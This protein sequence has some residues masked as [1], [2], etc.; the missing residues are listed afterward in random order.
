MRLI[1]I[2]TV[3]FSLFAGKEV[4]GQLKS[5]IIQDSYY[6]EDQFYLGSAYNVLSDLPQD[7]SQRNFSYGIFGGFIRDMPFNDSRTLAL[8]TGIGFGYYNY[9]YNL[10]AISGDNGIDYS[11]PAADEVLKRNKIE[12][13]LIEF[14]IELR[15]RNST[16]QDYSFWRIYTGFKFGYVYSGRSKFV[17]ALSK[18]SFENKDLQNWQYGVTLS[19]G[20]NAL[21]LN[22]YYGLN[23]VFEKETRTTSGQI[24][25]FTPVR[26]GLIFYIL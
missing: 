1:F 10:K 25:N 13:H 12:T 21:T 9:Y 16:P 20:Y 19:A 23:R 14:P 2:C 6:R 3:F 11:I 22:V 24:M 26:F 4:C 18:D 5:D 8:G 15:W 7:I 17:G